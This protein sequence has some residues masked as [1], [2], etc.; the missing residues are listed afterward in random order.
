MN[1]EKGRLVCFRIEIAMAGMPR[2]QP[3]RSSSLYG[4]SDVRVQ[5]SYDSEYKEALQQVLNRL[6]TLA[7]LPIYKKFR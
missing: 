4:L 2:L 6:N 7:A 5:F 3:V 1:E